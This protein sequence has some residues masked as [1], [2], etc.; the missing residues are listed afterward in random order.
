MEFEKE[1][2]NATF[3]EGINDKNPIPLKSQIFKY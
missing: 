1:T 3:K 2:Q